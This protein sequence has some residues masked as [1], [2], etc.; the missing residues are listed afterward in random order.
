M[1]KLIRVGMV[2][3]GS[4]SFMGDIHRAAIRESGAVELVCGSFGSTRHSSYEMCKQL[5]LPTKRSY[6]TYRDMLRR[7]TSVPEEERMQFVSIV[8][9][10]T[11]HYP[12][13]MSSIDAGFPIMTEKPFTCN[14]DEALNLT[15]KLRE[16]GLLYGVAIVHA[17]YPALQRARSLI[18]EEQ[19]LG[20]LRKVVSTF[21]LGWMAQRLETAGNRQASWRADPRRC[22]PG[23]ALADLGSHCLHLSEWVTGLSVAEVNADLRPTIAG[24]II[25]D[26]ATVLVRFDGG[27]RGVFICSQIA[28]GRREGLTLAV[29]GDKASLFWEQNNPG[30]LRMRDHTFEEKIIEVDTTKSATPMGSEPN[31]YGDNSAYIS[32]LAATYRSYA[33]VLTGKSSG[34]PLFA[35]IE[36]GLRGV[37]FIDTVLKNTTLDDEETPLPKWSEFEV[38]P[39]PVL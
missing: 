23:G 38:P 20:N 14:I 16:S 18:Q 22:G 15:R 29:Y 11:M 8:A 37:A 39:V 5:E 24:R 33:E 30:I 7:E 35:S 32:A 12:I 3:G 34:S 6:G 19:A 13:S 9:P 10:N 28:T 1:N 2:G 4:D 36:D 31:P 21:E 25:D 26:D 27:L 17:A